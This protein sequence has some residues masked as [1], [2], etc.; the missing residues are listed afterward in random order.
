MIE[1]IMLGH[2]SLVGKDTFYEFAKD[3]GYVRLAF[4][5][6]LKQIVMDLY[7]FNYDQLHGNSKDIEDFRYINTVDYNNSQTS[8]SDNT[9]T[10]TKN[11]KIYFTPRRILQIFGQD[12]RKLYPDIWASYI[13]YVEIPRLAALGFNKFIITDFRFKNEFKVASEW[14]QKTG[15]KLTVVKIHRDIIAK[16][17]KEDISEHD[18]DDFTYWEYT[19]NNTK[20]IN[21]YREN[22]LDF[23]KKLL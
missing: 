21:E 12:Q 13:F 11:S 23:I 5:D 9:L 15:N 3:F 14:E 20:S 16:S 18:L 8:N 17:G 10:Y 22:V 1:V 4:A 6:K 7:N 19:I 2:K